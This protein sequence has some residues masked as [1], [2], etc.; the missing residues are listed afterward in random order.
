M[1][2]LVSS[3]KRAKRSDEAWLLNGAIETD[4]TMA[5]D[6]AGPAYQINQPDDR[7]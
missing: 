1:S 6:L 5:A 3:T 4:E 7:L 2:A